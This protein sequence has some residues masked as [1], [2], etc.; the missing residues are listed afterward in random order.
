MTQPSATLGKVNERISSYLQERVKAGDFPSAVYLV[1][2]RD[3]ILLS[4]AV[5]RAVVE[6]EKI[7]ATP[8]T[9]YDLASLTKPLVTGLLT[10]IF[11]ER[12]I[13]S[14]DHRVS[15]HLGEFDVEAK[16]M[17]TVKDLVAH[18]S[19]LP[20]WK[21]FYL[22]APDPADVMATIGR[23]DIE[24]GADGVTY[25]DPNFIVLASL[26][27]RLSGT[28]LDKLAEEEIFRPLGIKD[29]CFNPA[30]EKR[31]RIAAS[32]KGN[33]YEMQTCR[34][35]GYDVPGGSNAFRT[36]VIWGQVHDCNAHFMNGVA[37]HAGLFSTAVDVFVIAKQFLPTSSKLLSR[38]TCGIFSQNLTAGLNE[39]RSFG[40]QL[41]ST[42]KSTA[43][44][45]MSPEAFGHLG[46]T[47]TSLWI[48]PVCERVYVLLTNRTHGHGLP[49]VNI[50]SARRR[51][52]ELAAAE[53]QKII[54]TKTPGG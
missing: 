43:G 4:G 33:E 28:D 36:D 44:S 35:L 23:L 38:E 40:F 14:V 16:R 6:P 20:S 27:E 8:D 45:Q 34:N 32:E 31:N 29:T 13:L 39:H 25:G 5:G 52:H 18:T 50:N 1:G 37:G 54:A 53:L 22:L 42:A 26:L 15:A 24:Y 46:F 19:H 17:I 30:A 7:D 10:A 47:G 9:I 3:E 49:F 48:D 41:A 11:I 51:F 2:E 12:G 21:P